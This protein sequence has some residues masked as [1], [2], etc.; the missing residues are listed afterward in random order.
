MA[1]SGGKGIQIIAVVHGEAQMR[2]R[3]GAD[4]A[5]S[6]MDT[7]GVKVLLPGVT[8]TQ[9]LDAFSKLCGQAAYREHGQEHDSRVPVLTP[10]M[11]RELPSMFGLVIRGGMSPVIMRIGAAWGDRLFKAARRRGLAV[12][13]IV[14]VGRQVPAEQLADLAPRLPGREPAPAEPDR[15]LTPVAASRDNPWS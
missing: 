13:Q 14:S 9:T 10:D 3:W 7:A 6:I 4:G 15:E 12:A 8:D 5:Q 1:D 2:T 11:I